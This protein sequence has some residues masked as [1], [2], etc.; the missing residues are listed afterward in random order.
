MKRLNFGCG[1][2]IKEGFDNVD[3]QKG[4]GI[5]SFDFNNFPYP[6]KDNTYDY[7]ELNQ[8]LNCLDKPDEVLYELRRISK[9]D[10]KIIII[11]PYYNNKGAYNDIQT[12]HWFNENSF[13][14]FIKQYPCRI[15]TKP[16][17][18]LIKLYKEP[19]IVGKF[20]PEIIRDKLNLFI[21]G[22]YSKIYV[23]LRVIK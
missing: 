12:I 22:L 11:V 10:C 3:I 8:V 7:I 17:F 5:N 16:K 19:T 9:P 14:N 6:I 2:N 13:S 1:N 20:L 18:E 23:E 4:S 15:D 21:G